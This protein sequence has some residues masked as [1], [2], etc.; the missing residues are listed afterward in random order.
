LID[1]DKC[2]IYG[3][4][5]DNPLFT[6]S[7][8]LRISAAIEAD[9]GTEVSGE[10][11]KM[12]LCGGIYAVAAFEFESKEEYSSVFNFLYNSWL[13]QLSYKS[14][15]SRYGYICFLNSPGEPVQ[16]VKVNMPIK[17]L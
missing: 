12:V 3:I 15:T 10:V 8:N 17:F 16:Q 14:D 11:G 7:S 5:H 6:A 13:R 4:Y 9:C 1:S 2:G